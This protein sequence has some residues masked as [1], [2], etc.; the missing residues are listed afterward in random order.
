[1]TK[2]LEAELAS[3]LNIEKLRFQQKVVELQEKLESCISTN[4]DMKNTIEGLELNAEQMK[5]IID[6]KNSEIESLSSKMNNIK[7]EFQDQ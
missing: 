2:T 4:D 6:M 7:K 5:N 3:Q 1:M